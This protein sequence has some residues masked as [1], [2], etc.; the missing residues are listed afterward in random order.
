MILDFIEL[1][2]LNCVT[3]LKSILFITI[4]DDHLVLKFRRASP[5]KVLP[6][7]AFER[8]PVKTGDRDNNNFG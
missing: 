8:G 1:L 3:D 4:T 6:A 2:E 7:S 5:L